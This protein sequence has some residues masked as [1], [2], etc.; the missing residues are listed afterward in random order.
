M[1]LR[2]IRHDVTVIERNPAGETYGWGLVFWDNL[3]DSLYRTD[4]PT[5]SA[6]RDSAIQWHDQE[7]HVLGR[8]IH[9][10]GYG[11]SLS[12]ERLLDILVQRATDLGAVVQFQRNVA[13]LSE[14]DTADLIVACDGAN[15]EIR[16]R[17]ANHFKTHVG[18][19]RN[20]YIWLGTTKIFDAFTFAFEET[21]F[22][23]I[24]FHAY[25]F[26][27][28]ASTCIVECAPQTW[29]GLG[30]DVMTPDQSTKILED[31]FERH[32]NGHPLITRT[33]AYRE[34]TWLSFA[35]ITNQTWFR[36]NVVLMGD[37]AHT[38]HFS[39]GSGTTL[40][41]EDAIAL[42][43]NL[44]R[45]NDLVANLEAYQHERKSALL[46]AQ[47][48]GQVSAEWFE[49]IDHRLSRDP[50]QLAFSLWRRRDSPNPPKKWLYYVH[51]ATQ[52]PALRRARRA[53]S[54]GRRWLRARIRD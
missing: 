29:N 9:I 44:H 26:H 54:S 32:L 5:A 15:S 53:V 34:T 51:L 3:I 45:H 4:P 25:R 18:E 17:H 50:L 7:V 33:D 6:I 8:R 49:S 42:A 39:I 27:P 14:L 20:K 35:R 13:D 28:G 21:A 38:T 31:I 22:G 2:D 46:A 24:W 10:G 41:I 52:W 1:K 40:A 12:R 11:F 37:A 30:F 36:N 19:G 47:K 48:E 23:W 16:R 43:Q